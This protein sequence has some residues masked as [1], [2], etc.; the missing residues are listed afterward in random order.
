MLDFNKDDFFVRIQS[1]ISNRYFS[2]IIFWVLLF[3]VFVALE[4]DNTSI[5]YTLIEE[6][7]NVS[8]FIV[9]VYFNLLYLI[10]KFLTQKN[11]FVYVTLLIIS[12]LLLSPIKTVAFY[13]FY[14]NEPSIQSFILDNQN[15]YFLSTVFVA[16][17]STV[18]KVMHDWILHQ[19]EMQ[20]LE[21]KTLESELNFLKS[22]INPH[23]LFNTLNNLYAL[24]LKKSDKA[25]EIVLRLSEMM[26]YM[27]YECNESQVLLSKEVNYL[28]NYLELEKLRQG[29]N[30][31]IGFDIHGDLENQTIAPL[32]F[33]PF[34]ENS[35]KHGLSKQISDGF[36]N[37]GIDINDKKLGLS[38]ENSKAPTVPSSLNGKKSGGIGL[39]NIKK[40]LE[41][42]Y[43]NQYLLNI[44]DRP[45]SYK[46][47]LSLELNT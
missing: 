36:V 3:T 28:K 14:S 39:L 43:P 33:I 47:S 11:F 32:M 9:I 2:H 46:I 18:Y 30:V 29:K 35:F 31:R 19:R 1:L 37:I 45:N 34:V 41:L 8:F 22:Q 10:P 4:R 24:T 38:V 27:L 15:M 17:C 42:L 16:V 6:L 26:R 12:C 21:N 40:R 20:E 44:E 7:L 25:P 23:F 13:F 5:L